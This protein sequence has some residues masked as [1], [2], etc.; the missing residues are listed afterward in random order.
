MSLLLNCEK[1]TKSFATRTLF[2]DI[3]ISFDDTERTGL[4]GPNGSG[5]STLLK[6]LAGLETPD[7]GSFT[8][9]RKLKLAYLPQQE[10]FDAGVTPLHLLMHAQ[11][12]AMSDEHERLIKAQILLDRVGFKQTEVAVESLSGGWRK[13]LAIARELIR[14]PDLLLLDEP[15]NHLDLEGILW[16][17]ELLSNA[18]FA[19]LL[20]SHDRYF[21]ENAANRIVELNATYADGYLSSTGSYADFLAKR[22][23]YLS[24]QAAEQQAV[25]SRVRREIEWLRRGAKARTTKAKGRIQ[26]AGRMMEDLAALKERNAE[27]GSVALEFNAT[28]RQTRKL[29]VLKDASKTMGDRPLFSHLNLVLSPGI[30]LGLL[31]P[32]GSGKTTLI[33]LLTGELSPD[34]GQVCAPKGCAPSSSTSRDSSSIAIKRFGGRSLPPATP[35][36]A[37]TN[38]CT[39][40]PGPG[41]SSSAST[42]STCRSA[43]CPAASNPES[44]SLT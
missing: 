35:S 22:E 44:C 39:Y 37:A 16:L 1:L 36:T 23:V 30:R 4:I 7:S 21:L 14:E 19:F 20:V 6:I 18:R 25:A 38:R 27:R 33:R 32:N 3:S 41:V 31:G 28:E 9:R 40:Q 15:T 42:S 34:A 26:Q 8:T 29:L 2:K 12:D 10:T 24:A 11:D 17:E 5:K 43:I 13:R